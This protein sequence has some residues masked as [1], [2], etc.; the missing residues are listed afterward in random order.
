MKVKLHCIK[1][2]IEETWYLNILLSLLNNVKN[3]IYK[4]LA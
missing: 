4:D 3:L 1:T 2:S